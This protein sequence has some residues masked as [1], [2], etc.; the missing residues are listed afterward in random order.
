MRLAQESSVRYLKSGPATGCGDTLVS[1]GRGRLRR[2]KLTEGLVIRSRRR[3]RGQQLGDVTLSALGRQVGAQAESSSSPIRVPGLSSVHPIAMT[4]TVATHAGAPLAQRV[5]IQRA[6][7][8]ASR[9]RRPRSQPWPP[10]SDHAKLASSI[11]ALVVR[12]A[13]RR[14]GPRTPFRR[15]DRSSKS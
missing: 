7:C 6:C 12:V 4:A 1:A 10:A 9:W 15:Q 3:D 14:E 8:T 13:S 2:T 5:E 11:V